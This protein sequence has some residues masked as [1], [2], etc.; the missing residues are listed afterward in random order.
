MF[1]SEFFCSKCNYRS[2]SFLELTG[3]FTPHYVSVRQDS[4]G[5]FRFVEVDKHHVENLISKEGLSEEAVFERIGQYDQRENETVV[6]ID[7]GKEQE[8][9]LKCPACGMISIHKTVVGI[10]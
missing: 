7:F 1:V 2:D 3:L 6:S 9:N 8:M 10:E 5:N 4:E